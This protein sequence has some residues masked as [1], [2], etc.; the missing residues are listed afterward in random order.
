MAC[1]RICVNPAG[2]RQIR[3]KTDQHFGTNINLPR[4]RFWL[5]RYLHRAASNPV[6]LHCTRYTTTHQQ[7]LYQ[8]N[9]IWCST[10]ETRFTDPKL[11]CYNC[12]HNDTSRLLQKLNR[13]VMAQ[14]QTQQPLTPYMPTTLQ[15]DQSPWH[16]CRVAGN[17]VWSYRACEYLWQCGRLDYDCILWNLPAL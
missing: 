7:Q 13:R 4:T 2:I 3:I 1:H 5:K 17:T 6:S 14:R 11:T 12:H 8:I 16:L 10:K 9:L 15:G